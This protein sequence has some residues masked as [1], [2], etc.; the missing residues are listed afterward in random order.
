M[1]KKGNGVGTKN[2]NE[3]L[4]TPNNYTAMAGFATHVR[5]PWRLWPRERE[6]DRYRETGK[7]DIEKAI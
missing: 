6:R 3:Y 4:M 7:R 2:Y 5:N 1:K